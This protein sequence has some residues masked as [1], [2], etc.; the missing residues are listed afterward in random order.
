FIDRF[1]RKR[2]LLFLYAG[3][4]AGTLLCALA[5]GYGWLMAARSVAGAFGGIVAAFVLVI[6]GDA[7]PELRRG[8]A[9]GV[10]MTAFSLASIAGIPAGIVLGNRFGAQSPFGILSAFC[11]V[12]F[13]VAIK[14]LPRMQGHL[15]HR[16]QS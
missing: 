6:I 1:D 13:I 11:A 7:F 16:R 5:P 10:V 2:A 3:L 15:S 8:R 9:T 12:V 14:A 4:T